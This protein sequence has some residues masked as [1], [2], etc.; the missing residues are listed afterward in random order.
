VA[1]FNS[2]GS[3]Y[4]FLTAVKSIFAFGDIIDN[5]QLKEILSDKYQGEVELFY[6][7]REAL[8]YGLKSLS[9]PK[10]SQVAIN[11]FTC[12]AVYDAVVAS[13]L[14]PVFLD[15]DESTLNFSPK[16][17][18]SH[19]DKNTKIRAVIVQNTFGAVCEIDKISEICK[20]NNIFLIEDLAHSVNSLY[21][22]KVKTGSYGDLVM[23]SFGRDKEIDLISGGAIINRS[24][25]SSLNNV[26]LVTLGKWTQHVDRWYPMHTW[27]VRKFFDVKIGQA[28]QIFWSKI[29]MLPKA[30]DWAAS[31]NTKLPG[32]YCRQ[33]LN[34]FEVQEKQTKRRREIA[35]IY[36]ENISPDLSLKNINK[37]IKTSSCLR[38]PIIVRNRDSLVEELK[39]DKFMLADVWYD[40]P[41]APPRYFKKTNY[42]K[43][44]CIK[45]EKVAE[46]IFNLP[47]H[48][49]ISPEKAFMLAKL[50]NNWHNGLKEKI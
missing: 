1:I 26:G 16:T 28:L 15:I 47:T 48:I 12:Y 19:L 25:K 40:T 17:L 46:G 6:K 13:G 50:I 44:Q 42:V 9:L 29:G 38:F 41:V 39:K 8:C 43:G 11:G 37:N 10:G 4:N 31:N 36:A 3:N 21:Q 5:S 2:L 23:I 45:S 35:K 7:G 18:L 33:I 32:W 30:V 14:E 27:L 34:K 24:K 20:K 49:N 22:D